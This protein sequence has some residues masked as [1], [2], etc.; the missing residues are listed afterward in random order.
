MQA[1]KHSITP[2]QLGLAAVPADAQGDDLVS[3]WARGR[4]RITPWVY[5]YL[6]ALGVIRLAVG[7]FLVVVSALLF[8]HGD[9]GWAS[10]P[11]AGAALH[12]AIGGLDLAAGCSAHARG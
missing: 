7:A 12:F 8:A 2:R 10:V 5:P 11:L 9:G 4:R 3:R 6:R 1:T